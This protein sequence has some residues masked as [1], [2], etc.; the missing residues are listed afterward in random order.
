MFNWR[1]EAYYRSDPWRGRWETEGGGVLVNQA[2]HHLDLLRWFMGPIEE[3]SGSWANLNHP[4]IEVEDTAVACVRFQ[5]GGLGSIVVSV[6]QRPGID[7]KVHI[8][9]RSGASIGVETDRG[10]TFV[11][12]L[13]AIAEPPLN[14]LWTI[15]GEEHRLAEFQAEDRE[16]FARNDPVTHYHSLQVR[17]FLRRGSTVARRWSRARTG[18]RSWRSSKRSIDRIASIGR[19]RWPSCRR[20]GREDCRRAETGRGH[21]SQCDPAGVVLSLGDFEAVRNRPFP[22]CPDGLNYRSPHRIAGSRSPT[23]RRPTW[24]VPPSSRL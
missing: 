21:A 17:D 19:S 11:A 1:D 5:G 22:P 4:T 15:P 13:S 10:A 2:P 3:I 6:S 8:H 7:S 23:A 14:D 12:G 24:D 16:E 9:G 20:V 18:A